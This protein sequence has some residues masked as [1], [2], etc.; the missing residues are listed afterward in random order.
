VRYQ[1]NHK[2]VIWVGS[3][4]H[5]LRDFPDIA[6]DKIGVALQKVQYGSRPVTIKTLSGFG[7]ASVLEIKVNDDSDAYRAVYTIRFADYIFVLHA[8]QKKSSHGI[9]T[10]K[11]DIDLIKSR[12][13]LAE[14]LYEEL[15]SHPNEER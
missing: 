3:S 15:I 6:Q 1:A 13:K 4:H 9:Q 7:G 2:P 11:Q 5:D 12:L 8:F 10:A 14:T